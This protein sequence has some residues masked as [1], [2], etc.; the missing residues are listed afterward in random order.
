MLNPTLTLNNF[1]Q[2][3]QGKFNG[4]KAALKMIMTL[5]SGVN[6]VNVFCAFFSYER[7]FGSFLLVTFGLVPKFTRE[8]R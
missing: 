3:T 5:T 7:R 2:K 8:K 4:A 6:F 1:C